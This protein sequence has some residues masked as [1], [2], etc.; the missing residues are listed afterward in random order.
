MLRIIR[1]SSSISVDY[2][3]VSLLEET[4]H[5]PVDLPPLNP[6]SWAACATLIF[7]SPDHQI[8]V[9][10]THLKHLPTPP[11]AS[12]TACP[13]RVCHSLFN[14]MCHFSFNATQ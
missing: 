9:P 10:L 12:P 1:R 6:I 7:P 11:E 8:P 3:R 2:R 14:Q 4:V 5:D 13:W